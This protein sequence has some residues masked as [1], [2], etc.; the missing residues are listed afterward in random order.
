MDARNLIKTLKR[1]G[2]NLWVDGDRIRI[3]A[4]QEPDRETKA[5]LDELRQHKAEVIEALIQEDPIVTQDIM[6]EEFRR[7]QSRILGSELK[8][9]DY[10]WLRQNRRDLY[11]DIKA[12]EAEMEATEDRPLSILLTLI[13]EWIEL[14][15]EGL[16]EQG[17]A[18]LAQEGSER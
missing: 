8:D 12:K 17:K 9:F 15:Q 2:L 5:L 1:R 7:C 16:R 6:M 11:G 14:I 13:R 10:G 18:R 4:P 3:A